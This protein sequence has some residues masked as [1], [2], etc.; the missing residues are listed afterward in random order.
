MENLIAEML[1]A[2]DNNEIERMN[3]LIEQILKEVL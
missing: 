1:K 3:A 2:S